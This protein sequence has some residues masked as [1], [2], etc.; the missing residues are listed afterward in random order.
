MSVDVPWMG[1]A[2]KSIYSKF[3]RHDVTYRKVLNDRHLLQGV[4]SVLSIG[5]GEGQLEAQLARDS[6]VHLGYIDRAESVLQAFNRLAQ[7]SRIEHL[8]IERHLGS[9]ESYRAERE[10]DLVIAIHSW[11]SIW[12]NQQMLQKA[13]DLVSAGGRLLISL[14]SQ[15]DHFKQQV[16]QDPLWA[17]ALSAWAQSEGLAH[18]FFTHTISLPLDGFFCNGELTEEVR[19]YVGFLNRV[20]WGDL[21]RSTRYR[22]R[23]F[24]IDRQSGGTIEKVD[25]CLIFG[26]A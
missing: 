13:L 21:P 4:R 15:E 10:Y 17:E 7:E 18:E 19:T 22:A 14:T 24:L 23:D 8:I 12:D 1:Q 16:W 6:G 3:I 11:Y 25:G 5:A 20:E 9:F 26:D 2:Y